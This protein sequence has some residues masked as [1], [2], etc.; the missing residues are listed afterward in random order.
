MWYMICD[1]WYMVYDIWCA[2]CDLSSCLHVLLAD[3][4]AWVH[5][6]SK[7]AVFV[8]LLP[9]ANPAALHNLLV[10][11]GYLCHHWRPVTCNLEMATALQHHLDYLASQPRMKC[12]RCGRVY[13]Q[14]YD[15]PRT[16][17]EGVAFKD[18]PSDWRCPQCGA[19]K[20]SYVRKA[21][22]VEFEKLSLISKAARKCAKTP[23]IVSTI[24][25]FIA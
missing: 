21:L 7:Q 23:S 10:T 18:V 15:C 3:I 8:V 19:E 6:C 22:A 16:W 24:V 9:I 25:D 1:I 4:L 14:V 20:T 5:H 2:L 12:S 13:S 11:A 17:G